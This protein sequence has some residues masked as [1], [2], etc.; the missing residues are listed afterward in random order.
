MVGYLLFVRRASKTFSSILGVVV[1][2]TGCQ[3]DEVVDDHLDG[4][5]DV[6]RDTIEGFEPIDGEAD[7][8][9]PFRFVDLPDCLQGENPPGCAA[10]P[11]MQD[12]T[13]PTGWLSEQVGAGEV[14]DHEICRPPA[15]LACSDLYQ[16]AGDT[17]C[18]SIG[19][20][21]PYGEERFHSEDEIRS[22]ADDLVGRIWY[23]D[24]EQGQGGD[25]SR[26]NP[27]QTVEEALESN[28]ASDD[29]VV[30][31]PGI[32]DDLI[33]IG[34]AES[35][36]TGFGLVGSCVSTTSLTAGIA[37]ANRG[38][39]VVANLTILGGI[40]HGLTAD[41]LSISLHLK[42]LALMGDGSG[43]GLLATGLVDL[44]LTEIVATNW[45]IGIALVQSARVE[46]NRLLATD[47][48]VVGLAFGET[49]NVSVSDVVFVDNSSGIVI[50]D[51]AHSRVS[52]EALV[53][54]DSQKGVHIRSGTVSIVQAFISDSL[55]YDD[56]GV[57]VLIEED[58]DVTIEEA[59]I[60]NSSHHGVFSTGNLSLSNSV[61]RGNGVDDLAAIDV[62]GRFSA[63]GLLADYN[64]TGV[65]VLNGDVDLHDCVFSEQT[66]DGLRIAETDLSLERSVFVDNAGAGI[67]SVLSNL[68]IQDVVVSENGDAS[69]MGVLL[70]ASQTHGTRVVVS[71]NR[72]VNLWV[73]LGSAHFEDSVFSFGNS[74]DAEADFGR[75]QGGIGIIA[76]PATG[77]RIERSAVISN[78]SL[79]TIIVG[80]GDPDAENC[81]NGIDDD[82]DGYT[83]CNDERCLGVDNCLNNNPIVLDHIVIRD[84]QPALCGEWDEENPDNCA[85]SGN[86]ERG[87]IGLAMN[88]YCRVE[89]SH[90]EISQ[91]TAVGIIVDEGSAFS[92]HHGEVFDNG[93]GIGIL[94]ND[95]D[96]DQLDEE[97]YIYDNGIDVYRGWIGVPD[98]SELLEGD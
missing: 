23:V 92:A 54:L 85:Q 48:T 63:T 16:F 15:R 57:G 70:Y 80:G 52:I 35:T 43:V 22:L 44:E 88:A 42:S 34:F 25:G 96:P 10:P 55:G 58:A 45:N 28:L 29:I 77:L 8:V 56:T 71:N 65:S 32:Y 19:T 74:I 13:C 37:I 69:L 21:C 67:T 33:A 72:L 49:T 61:I 2:L 1:M 78:R 4:F 94:A 84:T 20:A 95:F 51:A 91:S 6:A 83:D 86:P 47:N 31:A 39:S 3:G 5:T 38:P 68:S 17:S 18:R 98:P 79:G 26:S 87:G 11:E 41:D 30:L 90:F 40:E 24:V 76:Q 89:M 36:S 12:W 53:V 9:S 60:E 75:G 46:G 7:A 97:V 64:G 82:L 62:Q 59:L 73:Q 66:N 27:F 93:V 50:E 14:W 81:A